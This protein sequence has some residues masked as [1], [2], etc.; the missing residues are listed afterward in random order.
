MSN[1]NETSAVV[2]K[3]NVWGWIF[4][5]IVDPANT[6][7]QIAGRTAEPHPTDPAKTKDGT[8]WWLPV[9]V[10][11]LVAIVAT[12][13]IVP[14]VVMPMQEEALHAMIIEQGGTQADVDQAMSMAGKFTMPSAIIGAVIQ[15][16]IMLF[17]TAGVFHLLMKMVG[18]KGSFRSGRAVVAYSMI[19]SAI[20]SLVKLPIMI[21]KKTM[22]V[23]LGPTLL[24]PQLEPSDR[25]FKF[26]VTAFD[27]FTI[28][29]LIV[30]VI[31]LAAGYRVS[32]GKSVTVV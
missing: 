13:Y 20:G 28:W 26:L 18:G 22:T 1:G 25:L 12:I 6:F 19:I 11:A 31:G 17:V 4:G 2:Q 9:L 21:S 16:F 27:A 24:L 3:P 10:V 14:S 30:L 23:E 5:V 29:W 32:R 7:A 8:K 15:T